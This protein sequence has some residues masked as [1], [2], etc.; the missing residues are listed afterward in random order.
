M[1]GGARVQWY[2]DPPPA[3]DEVDQHPGRDR[4]SDLLGS[5]LADRLRLD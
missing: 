3:H 1:E 4:G 5:H 2:D